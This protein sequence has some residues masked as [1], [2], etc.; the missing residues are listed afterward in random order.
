H[1]GSIF[2]EVM[3]IIALVRKWLGLIFPLFA[4]VGDFRGLGTLKWILHFLLVALILGGL[5]Y[6]NKPTVSGVSRNVHS[7]S[8]FI[9]EFFLPILFILIYALGWFAWMVWKLLG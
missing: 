2:G 4:K 5:W 8:E 7:P 9:R 3:A 6:V 1:R